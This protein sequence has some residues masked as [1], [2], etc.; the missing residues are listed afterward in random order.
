MKKIYLKRYDNRRLY[1][2]AQKKYVNLSEI[3]EL[4]KKGYS[5]SVVDQKTGEDITNQ[6]LLQIIYNI[7][8]EHM[9]KISTSLLHKIIEFENYFYNEF[10][11]KYLENIYG[12]FNIFLEEK[13]SENKE[14][15]NG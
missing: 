9:S 6:V 11:L 5:I 8:I 4:I 15:E 12:M 14:G 13:K 2:T 3:N 10:F 1:N 7:A